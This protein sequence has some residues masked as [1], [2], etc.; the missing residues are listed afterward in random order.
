MFSRS[1]DSELA[2]AAA[3]EAVLE[4]AV[5]VPEEAVLE[6]AVVVVVLGWAVLE[7]VLEVVPE[8]V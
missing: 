6:I 4:E 5:V 7:T 2:A 8:M 1:M 3:V